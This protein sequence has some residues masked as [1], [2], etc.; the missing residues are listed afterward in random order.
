MTVDNFEL[1][2]ELLTFEDDDTFYHLQILKRRKENPEISHGNILLSTFYVRSAEHLQKLKDDVTA[3]C[4]ATNSRAYLNLTARSFRAASFEALKLTATALSN[5]SYRTHR[6][7]ESATGKTRRAGAPKRW[8]VDIDDMAWFAENEHL[9]V[10]AINA[11]A[12]LGCKL[13]D[14]VPT[15]NGVHLI[16]DPFNLQELHTWALEARMTLPDVH[17]N[18]PTI[19]YAAVI[20]QAE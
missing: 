13:I 9:L 7:F 1:L 14:K 10:T 18:N 11:C 8:I 12:P 3:I 6:S 15:P 19:L 2:E 5:E 20:D 4:D 16:M 17:K